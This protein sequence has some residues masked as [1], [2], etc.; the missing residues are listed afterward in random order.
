MNITKNDIGQECEINCDRVWAAAGDSIS[1]SPFVP[2][3][4][5]AV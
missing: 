4:P 1:D 5:S 2:T 3:K